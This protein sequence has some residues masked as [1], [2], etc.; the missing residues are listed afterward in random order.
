MRHVWSSPFYRCGN[1]DTDS[2][3]CPKS[4]KWRRSGDVNLNHLAPK[5]ICVGSLYLSGWSLQYNKEKHAGF[6]CRVQSMLAPERQYVE[7]EEH[8][9]RDPETCFPLEWPV[10]GLAHSL[11]LCFTGASQSQNEGLDSVLRWSLK[12]FPVEVFLPTKEVESLKVVLPPRPV[13][14]SRG[15]MC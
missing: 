3:T 14:R 8:L 13:P 7:W 11:W 1:C 10:G 9:D 15:F 12:L 6:Q 5:P 4:S 2:V